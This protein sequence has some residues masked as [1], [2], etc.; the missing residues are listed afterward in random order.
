MRNTEPREPAIPS[1]NRTASRILDWAVKIAMGSPTAHLR[2]HSVFEPL[3][4]RTLVRGQGRTGGGIEDRL[5]ESRGIA[6][7]QLF[8]DLRCVVKEVTLDF[9]RGYLLRVGTVF[10]P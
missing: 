2:L 1:R 8:A 6:G 7:A 3:Q 4:E 9:L 5:G 10:E